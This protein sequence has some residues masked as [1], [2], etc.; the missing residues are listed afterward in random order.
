MFNLLH[1]PPSPPAF[2]GDHVL[3][4]QDTTILLRL[5]IHW[6]SPLLSVGFPRP[7]EKEDLWQLPQKHTTGSV[8]DDVEINF[9]SRCPPEQRPFPLRH[10]LPNDA[11]VPDSKESLDDAENRA[12]DAKRKSTIKYD[13]SLTKALHRT[14]FVR[15]WSAG[16]CKPVGDTLKTATP[17]V[18]KLLLTWLTESYDY[19]CLTDEQRV[20]G[21][22]ERPK[23]ISIIK[24]TFVLTPTLRVRFCKR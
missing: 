3:P 1:P 19:Y 18:T 9:Y 11:E 17:L 23:G 21:V 5:I 7:L 14:F 22:M 10:K 6:L 20:S 12:P 16:V 4:E 24:I 8:T 15:F 2:P 13:S